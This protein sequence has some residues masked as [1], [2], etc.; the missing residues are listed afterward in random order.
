MFSSVILVEKT[1]QNNKV[2]EQSLGLLLEDLVVIPLWF[3][4]WGKR[5]L[6]LINH[7]VR[8]FLAGRLKQ[9]VNCSLNY[10]TKSCFYKIY[11]F[12]WK[13][14]IIDLFSIQ[15]VGLKVSNCNALALWPFRF[16]TAHSTRLA[17]STILFFF[18]IRPSYYSTIIIIITPNSIMSET[19]SVLVGWLVYLVGILVSTNFVFIWN[20]LFIF[21]GRRV[22]I[23]A[24]FIL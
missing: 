20:I 22:L 14:T 21:A 2:Y 12:F 23:L 13:Q 8:S 11:I 24:A 3:K 19:C 7:L 1:K 6:P 16:R 9:S 15:C 17:S 4:L 5:L 18:D 10:S